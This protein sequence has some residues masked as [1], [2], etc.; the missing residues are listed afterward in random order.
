VR[1]FLIDFPEKTIGLIS[2]D[3]SKGKLVEHF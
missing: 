2:V 1:S 3:P